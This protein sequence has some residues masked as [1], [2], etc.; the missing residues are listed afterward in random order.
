MP[1]QL[2]ALWS[3]TRQALAACI[4]HRADIWPTSRES[5]VW[6]TARQTVNGNHR[7]KHGMSVQHVS[8]H[9]CFHTTGK[10]QVALI[11]TERVCAAVA[12]AT[13]CH[14]VHRFGLEGRVHGLHSLEY[15]EFSGG[16]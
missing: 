9:T 3:H 4:M 5:V 12:R 15:V 14:V 16:T 1:K 11:H 10:M 6:P 13:A 2:A 8:Q 7:V